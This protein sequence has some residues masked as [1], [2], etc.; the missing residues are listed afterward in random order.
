MD[1]RASRMVRHFTSAMARIFNAFLDADFRWQALPELF[2]LWADGL[3]L[4]V[5]EEFGA[6]AAALHLAAQQERAALLRDSEY[7]ARF[8]KDWTDKFNPKFFH[9]DL[10]E[11]LVLACPDASVVGKSFTEIAKERGHDAIDTFLDLVAAHGTRLRWYTVMA[12]DRPEVIREMV[13]SP[14]VL[15]GFS[16]AG[17]HLRQ[18]AHY[19]F[20]LRMLRLVRESKIMSIERAVH[21]LTGEIASWLGIDAGTIE[22]GKRADIV[23][24]DPEA[25]DDELDK[26]IEAPMECFSG[27]SRMV[28]RNDRAVKLVLI[29]GK[30]AFE[31]GKP[32]PLL[33]R[34]KL[35][36]VLRA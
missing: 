15:I 32:S 10:S 17:A 19:N 23:V 20:P 26:A 5:F 29:D 24:V 31:A 18:M 1:L 34:E 25:L 11:S 6:G 22:V 33:G 27:F 36:R 12:N 21:R 35:G 8:R 3:D 16:D 2:D 30:P 28:R 7:R 9:R 4:V 14:D 13:S